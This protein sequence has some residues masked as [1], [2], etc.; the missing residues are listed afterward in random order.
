MAAIEN[1]KI[2]GLKIRESANDG[3]DFGTPDADYRFAFLGEDGAWHVKNA[4]AVVQYLPGDE[5]DYAQATTGVTVSGT[6][7]GAATTLVTGSAITYDGEPVYL[8]FYAPYTDTT[9]ILRFWLYDGASSTAN[10]I[11]LINLASGDHAPVNVKYR[12]TPSA[13]SHTYG[14]RASI[15]SGTCLVDAGA[16]GGALVPMFLRITKA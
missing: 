12:F 11:G 16:G 9:V 6:T 8:E 4:S 1:E 3:S 5:I 13:A 7:E 10:Q 2:Y 14:I 15:A